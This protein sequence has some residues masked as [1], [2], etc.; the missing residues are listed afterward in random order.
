MYTLSKWKATPALTAATFFLGAMILLCTFAT[1][2]MAAEKFP[3]YPCIQPNVHFWEQV[4]SRYTTRQGILHDIDNLSQVYSIIDLVDPKIPGATAINNARISSKKEQLKNILTRLGNG[5]PPRTAE[6]RRIASLFHKQPRSAFHKAKDNFR[7]QLGQK[8]RFH[9]GVIRSGKYLAQFQKIFTAHRLPV[10]L[11]YLPHVES[12][13]NPKAYSKA[14]AAG[15][16]QF[17]RSTG[18]DYMNINQLVDERYDPYLA[19]QA[20]ARLLKEN[21]AALQSWPLAIT[22]YNYG[23]AGMMRALKEHGSYVN[24]FNSYDQGYFKFASR[25]FYAEF[26]AATRV[27]KR[28][29]K[30]PNLVPEKPEA[31]FTLRLKEDTPITRL[32]TTFGLNHEQFIRLNPALQKPVISG[33]HPVPKGALVRLPAKARAKESRVAFINPPKSPAIKMPSKLAAPRGSSGVRYSMN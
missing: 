31:T 30:L 20:A 23:K 14:G 24:I 3:L 26:V 9:E 29:E 1:G 10:E 32:R 2:A 12:S 27:A 5:Q 21:Y 22:A 18:K 11:A 6:E 28:W 33:Q 25:N 4:Y 8:D 7:F 16:W 17:T 15:L 19:T 13:F